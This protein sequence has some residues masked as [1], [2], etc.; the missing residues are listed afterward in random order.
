MRKLPTQHSAHNFVNTVI[1]KDHGPK[2][3]LRNYFI[4]EIQSLYWTEKHLLKVIPKIES[5][6]RTIELK[7]ALEDHSSVT[8]DH[9]ERLE[10]IFEMLKEVTQ[11]RKC[12][13]MDG[14]I[15]E[16]NQFMQRLGEHDLVRDAGM[17]VTLKKM[18]H[19]Q[20]AVYESLFYLAKILGEPLVAGILLRSLTDDKKALEIF[21]RL[22]E[23]HIHENALLES[24][25]E[26]EDAE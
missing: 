19:Y 18:Q 22:V 4:A 12:D 5:A 8:D 17:M 11:V 21:S 26:L 6:V 20:V 16:A 25:N 10:Q 7:E 1:H 24:E 15:K 9:V 23:S 3:S 2:D 13:T 14:L